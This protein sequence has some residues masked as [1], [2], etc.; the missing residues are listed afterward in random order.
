VQDGDGY[1][2]RY[3]SKPRISLTAV[4]LQLSQVLPYT[5]LGTLLFL[6]ASNSPL[7]QYFSAYLVLLAAQLGTLGI[8]LV[9]RRFKSSNRHI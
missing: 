8:Y 7:N 6:G 3:I 9:Q 4:R 2:R 5:I 1:N